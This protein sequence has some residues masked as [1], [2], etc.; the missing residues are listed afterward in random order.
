MQAAYDLIHSSGAAQQA[1]LLPWS[2]YVR[3]E[4]LPSEEQLT[5]AYRA[6]QSV[7]PRTQALSE[8][9]RPSDLG[10]LGQT[11][12]GVRVLL[13]DDPIFRMGLTIH[14]DEREWRA[15]YNS[16]TAIST[17]VYNL[18]RTIL[19]YGYSIDTP[20]SRRSSKAAML[21]KEFTE[22]ACKRIAYFP[23]VL[24]QAARGY[25]WGWLPL[26]R[27]WFEEDGK[28]P[29]RF[30]YRG[31][32]FIGIREIVEQFSE[33]FAFTEDKRFVFVGDGIHPAAI[34]DSPG[35]R[36]AW[37]ILRFGSTR[38]PYAA[39]RLSPLWIDWYILK[40]F[41]Q[42]YETGARDALE[43]LPVFEQK[44]GGI[45][46]APVADTSG[47]DRTAI[48]AQLYQDIQVA[49]RFKKEAG[50]LVIPG[51]Y[52]FKENLKVESARGWQ[53]ALEYQRTQLQIAIE[54]QT[55]TSSVGVDGGSR[56]LGDVHQATKL[57]NCKA[58]ASML[59]PQIGGIFHDIINVNIPSA[60]PEDLPEF[61]FRIMR[62]VD[63]EKLVIFLNAGGEA[64]LTQTA[65]DFGIPL[66]ALD[67]EGVPLGPVLRG[68]SAFA[69]LPSSSLPSETDPREGS[70]PSDSADDSAEPSRQP[71]G[72]AAATT[73]TP[74]SGEAGL[75][76]QSSQ[77]LNGAQIT[78]AIDVV[79]ELRLGVIGPK[80]A[81]ELLVA[82]GL[83]RERAQEIV[84]ETEAAPPLDLNSNSAAVPQAPSLPREPST[85]ALPPAL[86]DLAEEA[87]AAANSMGALEGQRVARE[88]GE[89][90]SGLRDAVLEVAE[91][92]ASPFA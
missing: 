44:S 40:R 81:V 59:G 66:P 13:R 46:G 80:A 41:K 76:V 52:T 83:L 60:D 6:A 5:L 25:F 16:E 48:T 29:Y 61:V 64:D 22:A 10:L 69:A 65:E 17:P 2:P 62:R 53:E 82:V 84:N 15:M 91:D 78:A 43:G 79:K 68:Q 57:E 56:A 70:P 12:S 72:G 9:L 77:T 88:F 47:K 18:I 19:G 14:R 58:L 32:Q 71:S 75:A 3:S 31:R 87:D 8:I 89:Y 28:T 34:Y 55:L 26:Q 42:F 4:P 50:A 63:K 21:L 45:Q 11:I 74:A 92:G 33:Y 49:L 35:D 30:S 1:I 86:D 73:Q 24:E 7:L 67:E 20:N 38:S 23:T 85:R 51:N 39:S 54:G 27:I 37:T 36:L 90:M